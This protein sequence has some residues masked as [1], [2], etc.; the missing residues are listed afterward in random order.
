MAANRP[1]PKQADQRNHGG[2]PRDHTTR[3]RRCPQLQRRWQH[4]AA[5]VS[6]R[7]AGDD[8]QQVRLRC[9]TLRRLHRTR[10]WRSGARLI[11]GL[12]RRYRPVLPSSPPPHCHPGRPSGEP[13]PCPGI[14]PTA[15]GKNAL[16]PV[17]LSETLQLG[18][19]GAGPAATAVRAPG[20]L[21]PR[22]ERGSP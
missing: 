12:L 3:E 22:G 16:D 5:L 14:E 10:R 7:R 9:G 19:G 6:A 4:A 18:A 13:I 2:L 8:W 15:S 21:C 17:A 11:F 20:A 1:M